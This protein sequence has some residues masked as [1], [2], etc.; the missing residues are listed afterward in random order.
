MPYV[1][2][3]LD[4]ILVTVTSEEKHLRNLYKVLSWLKKSGLRLKCDFILEEVVFLGHKISA[5][6]V[7]PVRKSPS[8][9]RRAL[10]AVSE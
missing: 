3:Y 7:Q 9:P 10:T 2:V 1:K 4:D 5:A 8:G 6:G